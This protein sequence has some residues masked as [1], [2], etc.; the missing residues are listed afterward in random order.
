MLSIFSLI[1]MLYLWWTRQR[2]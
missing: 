2:K 1:D